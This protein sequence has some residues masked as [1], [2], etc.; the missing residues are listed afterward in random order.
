[1]N[2]NLQKSR[3]LWNRERL[4]LGSDEVIAQLLERGEIAAWRELYALARND[5]V[6][7]ARISR[8]VHTVPLP[9]PYFWL[10]ALSTLGETVD[11]GRV[12]AGYG[13]SDV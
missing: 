7:R 12:P 10:A 13:L 5:D 2:D 6:L 8:V 11:W 3:A 9:S 4:E 1:M